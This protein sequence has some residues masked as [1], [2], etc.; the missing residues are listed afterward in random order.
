[1]ASPEELQAKDQDGVLKDAEP[2]TVIF[3]EKD[4][5]YVQTKKGAVKIL[6]VQPE[7]KKR[8]AVKDFLRG[9]PVKAGDKL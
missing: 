8:M 6:E 9:Y 7:G 3:V 2:G 4:A 5:F 1:M